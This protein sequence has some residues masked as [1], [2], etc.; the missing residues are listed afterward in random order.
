MGERVMMKG[1][2]AIGLGAIYAGCRY[3]YGYPITPQTELLEYM[4]R[5]LPELGGIYLQSESEI[6]GISMVYG[7]ASTGKRVMTS[8]SSPGISLMQEGISFLASAELPAVIVNVSRSGPGLG[9]VAPAQSDYFQATKGGGHGDYHLPVFTPASVQE[10]FSLTV[11]AF[12]V[13]DEYRTPV[14]ILADAIGGQMMESFN[15]PDGPEPQVH[16]NSWA[17]NAEDNR[18]RRRIL[19]AP[20]TDDELIKLNKHLQAKYKRITEKETSWQEEYLD[21]AEIVIAAFGTSA[22]IAEAAVDEARARGWQV[23]LIRPITV[24]PFPFAPFEKIK[25]RVTDVL[26]V[27]MNEGQ[28][29]EDVTLAMGGEGTVHFLGGGGGKVP[30]IQEVLDRIE[31][32]RGR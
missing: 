22:R 10:M 16:I 30:N 24:W 12:E 27:E 23:G 18:E 20:Y 21:E 5:R 4:A 11:R 17:I 9:R 28:M 13:A 7:T 15:L 29:L 3:Y 8:S 25:D 14:M 19:S 6:A 26:V 32:I 2:E 31:S 1:N